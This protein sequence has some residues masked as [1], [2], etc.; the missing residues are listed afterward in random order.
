MNDKYKTY[1]KEFLN[2]DVSGLSSDE[3]E[4]KLQQ[5]IEKNNNLINLKQEKNKLLKEKINIIFDL[6][7]PEEK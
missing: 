7:E 6:V 1:L 3:I 2:I 5:I 4:K